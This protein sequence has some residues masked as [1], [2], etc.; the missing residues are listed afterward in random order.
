MRRYTNLRL[1]LPLPIKGGFEA[2]KTKFHPG[3]RLAHDLDRLV[4]ARLN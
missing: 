2:E 4:V 3:L 1:P